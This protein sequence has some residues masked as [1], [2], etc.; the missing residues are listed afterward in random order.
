VT[1]GDFVQV[2]K[3]AVIGTKLFD[4]VTHDGGK[5]W[6]APTLISGSLDQG[7]VATPTVTSDGRIFVSFLDTVNLDPTSAG[8]GRDDYMV[9]QVD[10]QSGAPLESPQTVGG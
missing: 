6:S 3:G 7:F 4:S 1:W 8:F 10:S 9:V 5:T 2:Q